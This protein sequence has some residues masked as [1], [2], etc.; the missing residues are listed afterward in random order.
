[1]YV[2]WL[3]EQSGDTAPYIFVA[4]R[5]QASLRHPDAKK[6][7]ESL[8]SMKAAHLW[9]AHFLGWLWHRHPALAS[10]AQTLCRQYQP[11][12]LPGRW[13]Y[14]GRRYQDMLDLVDSL[15]I[16]EE[17]DDDWYARMAEGADWLDEEGMSWWDIADD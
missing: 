11:N 2:E 5:E 8:E 14:E 16:P 10:D 13:L 6:R 17:S 9:V 1:M 4:E 3:P 7:A 15:P 12:D